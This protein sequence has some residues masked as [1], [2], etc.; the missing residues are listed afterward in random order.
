MT[1]AYRR[2]R[3]KINRDTADPMRHPPHV[4]GER[5]L[6]CKPLPRTPEQR[7]AAEVQAAQRKIELMEHTSPLQVM[8]QRS[9]LAMGVIRRVGNAPH[10]PDH[11]GAGNRRRR[12]GNRKGGRRGS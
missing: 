10:D 12:S 9:L 8:A 3:Q 7:A 4:P 2:A 11:H 6:I 5:C 1:T